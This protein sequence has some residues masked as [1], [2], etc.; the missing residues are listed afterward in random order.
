MDNH[1]NDN[2]NQDQLSKELPDLLSMTKSPPLVEDAGIEY[3]TPAGE[4]AS[5][6][7]IHPSELKYKLEGVL[8][9]SSGQY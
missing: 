4:R 8:G 9:S 2:Y 5:K 3:I 7:H 1:P 6:G